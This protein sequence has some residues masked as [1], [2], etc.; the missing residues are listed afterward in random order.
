VRP[1]SLRY[2]AVTDH[3]YTVVRLRCARLPLFMRRGASIALLLVLLSILLAPMMQGAPVALP[4]CCRVGG[5]HHCMG[6][7]GNDG[8][9][10][11]SESCPYRTSPAVTG[12]IVALL[13]VP[14]ERSVFT[15]NSH[16]VGTPA[17]TAV[18]ESFDSVS[19]R[20]P[21]LG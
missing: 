7:P 12:G 19:Q 8:F 5:N 17:R 6:T 18:R 2:L 3:S 1:L 10:S 21:P 15:V 20:G 16:A 11:Q 14:T 9:R 4:A 13:S